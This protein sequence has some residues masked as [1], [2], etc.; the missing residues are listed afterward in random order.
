MTHRCQHVA[1]HAGPAQRRARIAVAAAAAPAIGP[2]AA[3][4]PKTAAAAPAIGRIGAV[5]P[6]FVAMRQLA[7]FFEGHREP[8]VAAHRLDHRPEPATPEHLPLLK[9]G[10]AQR[11]CERLGHSVGG[12][13]GALGTAGEVEGAAA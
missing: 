9:Q 12:G 8:R 1:L 11:R 6:A 13:V 5:E 10:G 3:A 4:A 2:D 7:H